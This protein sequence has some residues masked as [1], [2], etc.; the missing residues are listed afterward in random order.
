MPDRGGL[1]FG[2]ELKITVKYPFNFLVLSGFGLDPITL[3]AE[4]RMRME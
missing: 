3:T 1:L 4:T 2:K